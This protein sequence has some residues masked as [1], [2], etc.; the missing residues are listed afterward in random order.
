M[1]YAFHIFVHADD[2]TKVSY[3]QSCFEAAVIVG[4]LHFLSSCYSTGGYFIVWARASKG[5]YFVDKPQALYN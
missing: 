2:C 4:R 3:V 5:S 1:Y